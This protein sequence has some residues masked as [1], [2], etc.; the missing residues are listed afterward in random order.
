MADTYIYLGESEK[1]IGTGANDNYDLQ[2]CMYAAFVICYLYQWYWN[3]S[4][5]FSC[6]TRLLRTVSGRAVVRR[7]GTP[8]DAD[9][10][11]CA[12]ADDDSVK[13]M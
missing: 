13:V 11:L 3:I 2:K 10:W 8:T 4:S 6:L 9:R 12:K 7:S 1:A 5:I